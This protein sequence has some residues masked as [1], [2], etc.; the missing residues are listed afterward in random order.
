VVVVVVVVAVERGSGTLDVRGVRV[1]IVIGVVISTWLGV[2][3]APSQASMNLSVDPTDVAASKQLVLRSVGT[4]TNVVFVRWEDPGYVISSAGSPLM[5][6]QGCLVVDLDVAVC[7]GPIVSA[8]VVG[9][10]GTDVV[11]FTGVP[12]PVAGDGGRGDDALTGGTATNTL[13]GGDGVDQLTG[14]PQRDELAGGDGDDWLRGLAAADSLFGDAGDDIV[15]G[16][17]GSGDLLA[18]GTGRDLLEGGEGSDVLK[19]DSGSDVL[20]GGS[21]SDNI[22]PGRG[23][24]TVVRLRDSDQLSCPTKVTG[25]KIRRLRCATIKSTPPPTAWPP[26]SGA[27]SATASRD[28]PFAAPDVAGNATAVIVHVP[29]KQSRPIK[30]CLRTY[31]DRGR[32]VPLHPRHRITFRSKFWPTVYEP[33]PNPKARTARITSA[34][35]CPR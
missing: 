21:G 30:R 6:G 23:A 19:G 20:A 7:V 1:A 25:N 22:V 8:S 33:E 10:D 2:A 12:V 11:D 32:R 27:T 5:A 29:A 13:K 4:D 35:R 16:G 24:D 31:S 28:R 34:K 15:E 14:G 9:G 17:A 3:P 18:G 26:A